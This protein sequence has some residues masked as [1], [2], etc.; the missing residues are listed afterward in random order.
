VQTEE[1]K[2][3]KKNKKK[4]EQATGTTCL[5]SS[6][7]AMRRRE[8][9]TIIYSSTLSL[10]ALVIFPSTRQPRR[11]KKKKK[12]PRFI[13][14]VPF[15]FATAVGKSCLLFQFTDKIF[16]EEYELT[17]GVEF[18]TRIIDLEDKKVKLQL[19]DTV[20]SLARSP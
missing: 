14:H 9:T 12:I 11:E 8:A 16:Q 20:S 2:E 10:A 17:V 13:V 7:V 5:L 3:K 15:F 18:G 1:P 4:I 6:A 19:W